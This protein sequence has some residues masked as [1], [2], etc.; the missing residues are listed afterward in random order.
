MRA[1][2][3]RR[4][5]HA[6]RCRHSA[7]P[8]HRAGAFHPFHLSDGFADAGWAAMDIAPSLATSSTTSRGSPPSGYGAALVSPST[9]TWPRR[10]GDLD[11]VDA[12]HPT[13]ICRRLRLARPVTVIGQH[14]ELQT[15]PGRRFGNLID[16]ARAVRADGMDVN[17]ASDR[18]RDVGGRWQ[19]DGSRRQHDDRGDHGDARE[20]QHDDP[21]T[22]ARSTSTRRPAGERSS[23]CCWFDLRRVIQARGWNRS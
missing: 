16:G 15:G 19:R 4:V 6:I 12:E 18:L 8:G 17:D 10:R 20:R 13:T 23:A 5:H 22:H 21:P 9:T 11:G 1:R 14:H 7:I 3:T 2:A